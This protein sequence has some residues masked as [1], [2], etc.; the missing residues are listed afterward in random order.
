MH[1][2]SSHLVMMHAYDSDEHTNVAAGQQ[3]SQNIICIV[4]IIRCVQNC[5][6]YYTLNNIADPR[7]AQR[8]RIHT[9]NSLMCKIRV[10][11]VLIEM[12]S[13]AR[14]TTAHNNSNKSRFGIVCQCFVTMQYDF[15]FSIF[16]VHHLN[17]M[18]VPMPIQMLHYFLMIKYAFVCFHVTYHVFPFQFVCQLIR[19]KVAHSQS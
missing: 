7:T 3:I 5:F 19:M 14:R 16:P 4:C 6:G 1:I 12:P 8:G 13:F 18:S 11:N 17:T 2:K 15:V 9:Q 10:G